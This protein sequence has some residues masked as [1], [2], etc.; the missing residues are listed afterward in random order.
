MR[1]EFGDFTVPSNTRGGI[2]FGWIGFWLW[3]TCSA[4]PLLSPVLNNSLLSTPSHF[5]LSILLRCDSVYRN[6]CST[7]LHRPTVIAVQERRPRAQ[8]L[9][10]TLKRKENQRL[11]TLWQYLTQCLHSIRAQCVIV[12]A[13]VCLSRLRAVNS[14]CSL[15]RHTAPRVQH[16]PACQETIEKGSATT[17]EII[18]IRSLSEA[19][20]KSSRDADRMRLGCPTAAESC[21]AGPLFL[22]VALGSPVGALC[23]E[24]RVIMVLYV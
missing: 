9:Q 6:A 18:I 8:T 24:F 22:Y 13:H 21:L 11:K 2:G 7:T 23:F 16:V 17:K 4:S 3:A 19:S 20:C 5:P 10:R 14:A 12:G 15:S 1:Q